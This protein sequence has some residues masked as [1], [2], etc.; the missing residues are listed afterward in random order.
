MVVTTNLFGQDDSSTIFFDASL[1]ERFESWDG[2]NA[3]NYQDPNGVGNLN[4]NILFQRVI[5]GFQYTPNDEITIS[6][7]LQDSRAFGWSLRDSK[8]PD[9]FKIR[10]PN[11]EVPYYIRNPNEEFF[12]IHKLKILNCYKLFG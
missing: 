10:A 4:D 6:A 5:A 12:E 2:M 8:Y 7:H 9:L 3:K 1:R 11:T